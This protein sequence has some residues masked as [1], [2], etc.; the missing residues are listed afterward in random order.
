[1]V[2]LNLLLRGVVALDDRFARQV[3]LPG[4]VR[5]AEAEAR[6]RQPLAR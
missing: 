3:D 5:I 2:G 4:A 6:E 1:M